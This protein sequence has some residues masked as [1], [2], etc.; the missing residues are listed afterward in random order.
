MLGEVLAV[1]GQGTGPPRTEGEGRIFTVP[2]ALTALRLACLP[3]F[4]WSLAEPRG[5]GQQGQR[6]GGGR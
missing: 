2:N 6:L 1:A 4:G 5:L 3:G